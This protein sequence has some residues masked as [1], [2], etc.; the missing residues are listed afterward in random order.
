MAFRSSPKAPEGASLAVH[1]DNLA[2]SIEMSSDDPTAAFDDNFFDLLP[3]ETRKI[4]LTTRLP[5]AQIRSSLHV[6]S[7]VDAFPGR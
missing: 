4:R 3:G 6:R 7:L 1:S 2:R 5:L